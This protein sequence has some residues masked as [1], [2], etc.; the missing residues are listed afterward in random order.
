MRIKGVI[1]NIVLGGKN[2]KGKRWGLFQK[3]KSLSFNFFANM[4]VLG[5]FLSGVEQVVANLARQVTRKDG[6]KLVIIDFSSRNNFG[7]VV[8]DAVESVY[9]PAIL[10]AL[11]QNAKG[12]FDSLN[13][14][15]SG[16]EVY[17][18]AA[19]PAQINSML[20]ARILALTELINVVAKSQ[21]DI[22]FVLADAIT[23]L[24]AVNSVLCKRVLDDL[25]SLL[26]QKHIPIIFTESGDGLG[27]STGI[28]PTSSA[29]HSKYDHFV[30]GFDDALQCVLDLRKEVK[31]TPQKII[32]LSHADCLCWLKGME[33]LQE[34][35]FGFLLNETR[36][37]L[38]RLA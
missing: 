34:L 35:R 12:F 14:R 18:F 15:V 23:S 3:P 8:K 19:K 37:S 6:R 24:R 20:D 30:N 32:K 16:S 28:G 13:S 9:H 4:L 10:D 1:V 33:S 25:V 5:T 2:V 27:V 38:K 36:Q 21:G 11:H 7:Y 17:Y 31:V 26:I 22:V 29:F